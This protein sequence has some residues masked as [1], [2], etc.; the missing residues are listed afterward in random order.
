[1]SLGKNIEK[2]RK[3]LG[4]SREKLALKCGGKFTSIHLMRVEKGL[5]KNPGIELVK[6]VAEGLKV[7]IDDLI[8]G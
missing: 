2:Y 8:K 3:K 6:A 7:K 5:V 4:L 1:M